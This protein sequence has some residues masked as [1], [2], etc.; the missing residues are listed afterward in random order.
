MTLRRRRAGLLLLSLGF[1]MGWAP[2]LHGQAPD[3]GEPP[4]VAAFIQRLDSLRRAAD[5]PGL[6]VAVLADGAIVIAAGLGYADLEAHV[7]ATAETAYNV[8][9]VTKP[10]S[11]VLALRLVETGVLDL[12]RPMVEYSEWA[13]FCSA[14][15]EQPSIFARGLR[16]RPP[17]HTIRHLLSHTAA[18]T[19]GTAFSYNPVLYSWAS[20]PISAAAGAPFSELVTRFVL[21]PAGMTASARTHR[22]LPLPRAIAERLAPPHRVDSTGAVVRAPPPPPQGDGAAGGIISTVLDLARF[23]VALDGGVLISD[24]SREAM[25][26]PTVSNAGESLPYGLGWFVEDYRGERLVWHS[27]WWEDAYSALYLKVP[28][29]RLTF[30]VLANSEGIWWDNPLDRAEVEQSAF[31]R[32]FLTTFV[33]P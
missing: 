12:D 8:A 31:A 25:M 5:I 33:D 32:A 9:S 13:D 18:G 3:G 6:A 14:F 26:A 21:E 11:A 23:D 24:A 4:D 22:D 17:R 7:P 2:T 28:S 10:I 15:S 20:R 29:R 1:G 19:P 16:C 27:G 30:I